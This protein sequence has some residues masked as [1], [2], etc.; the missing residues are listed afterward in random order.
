WA[1]ELRSTYPA[2]HQWYSIYLYCRD[3]CEG[4]EGTASDPETDTVQIELGPTH[5]NRLF[6]RI[7]ATTP[8]VSEEVQ[9]SCIVAREQVEAGNYNGAYLAL[10]RWWSLG[11][12]PL[13]ESLDQRS[14]ADLLFTC[15]VLAGILASKSQIPSGQKQ[16]QGLLNGSI[17]LFEQVGSRV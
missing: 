1:A 9:M 17:A 3:L 13:L 7:Q 4:S 15:G 2:A 6:R 8:M 11:Q 12:W 10:K 14:S 16:A 5:P